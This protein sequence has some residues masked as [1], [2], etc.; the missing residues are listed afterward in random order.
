ECSSIDDSGAG[1]PLESESDVG[2]AS[3][4]ELQVKP[5]AR[6]VRDMAILRQ[7]PT[8]E[9]HL[10]A[11]EY[12]LHRER[13]AGPSLAPGAMANGHSDWITAGR[14]AYCPAHA[15]PFM[16]L[17]HRLFLHRGFYGYR[18]AFAFCP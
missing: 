9:L 16:P 18:M 11:I 1:P 2:S 17:R 6:L 7:Q 5:A 15:P 3:R 8:V 14:V 13:A 4:A 12:G 10:V